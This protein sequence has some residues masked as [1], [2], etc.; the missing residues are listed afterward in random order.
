MDSSTVAA[1]TTTPR[2]VE[3]PRPDGI[4]LP[5]R[6]PNLWYGPPAPLARWAAD[7][8]RLHAP[9]DFS[10]RAGALVAARSDEENPKSLFVAWCLEPAYHPIVGTSKTYPTLPAADALVAPMEDDVFESVAQDL[11]MPFADGSSR[12]LLNLAQELTARKP[13]SIARGGGAGLKLTYAH[14]NRAMADAFAAPAVRLGILMNTEGVRLGLKPLAYMEWW[15]GSSPAHDVKWDG[16]P[17]SPRTT[18]KPVIE[19]L[20]EAW[21]PAPDPRFHD[22]AVAALAPR[23][24]EGA[25]D[26]IVI[27]KPSGL[28]SVPGAMGLPDAMS[29]TAKATGTTLV[30]VHRLDMDTSGLLVY[31]KTER[32]TKALMAAFR[33]GQVDKR[34]RA[35]LARRLPDTLGNSG[36]VRFPI[37]TNPLDRLRQCAAVGGRESVTRWRVL[38]KSSDRTLVEMEPVTGRTHQ[39]R[40]H[41]AHAQGLNAPMVNDPYYGFD[42]IASE[43]PATP[44]NLHAAMLDFPDPATGERRRFETEPAFHL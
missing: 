27:E 35:L 24:L 17:L 5:N 4:A 6:L 31:A 36:E 30:P 23:I 43:T 9:S 22:P 29:M 40:L 13:K 1:A 26:W 33:E 15:V 11:V 14:W 41:A 28:L 10:G 38:E 16:M 20:W 18:A 12:T 37:T 3:L 19:H 32:G 8:T 34:Y 7:M 39:L 25:E 21:S 42:G 44:L 2:F